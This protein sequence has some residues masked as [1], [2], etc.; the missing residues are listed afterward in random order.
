MCDMR[1]TNLEVST[2]RVQGAPVCVVPRIRQVTVAPVPLALLLSQ[3]ILKGT[4][5]RSH[6]LS[7]LFS[8]P[9][10]TTSTM[11]S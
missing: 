7:F 2:R 9:T 5:A 4:T 8:E 11:N 3:Q 10:S 6:A 1:Q